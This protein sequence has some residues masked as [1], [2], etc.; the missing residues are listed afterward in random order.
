MHESPGP[1]C[2]VSSGPETDAR[3]YSE[4][5]EKCG[6]ETNVCSADHNPDHKG[7]ESTD[8]KYQA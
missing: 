7:D 4:R 6:Q 3:R 5:G 2:P 1:P 8:E